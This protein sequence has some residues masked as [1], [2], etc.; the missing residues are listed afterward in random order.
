MDTGGGD[1]AEWSNSERSRAAA[2]ADLTGRSSTIEHVG[3]FQPFAAGGFSA[4]DPVLST[5]ATA[6]IA[7]NDLMALGLVA[8]SRDRGLSVL[9]DPSV[10]GFDDVLFA[11]SVS[12]PLTTISMPLVRLGTQS[13]EVLLEYLTTGVAPDSPSP[14][15]AQLVVRGS[16]GVPRVPGRA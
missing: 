13:F 7:F 1:E 15:T 11:D 9:A 14:H 3:N 6:A 12:P 4:A 5:G 10:T 2:V 16:T 8:R